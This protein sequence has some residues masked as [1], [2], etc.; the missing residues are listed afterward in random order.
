MVTSV[1]GATAVDG[2]SG[3]LGGEGD[4]LVFRAARS[5]ADTIVVGAGT[6]IAES[7]GPPVL[8]EELIAARVADGQDAL[9]RIVVVSNSLG[10][11]TRNPESLAI[12][13]FSTE[14][15]RPTV[16]T[17]ASTPQDRVSM[18]QEVA[19]VVVVGESEV[20]LPAMFA[21][22][23]SEGT[24]HALLE[25]GP[26]LN[27]HM[28]AAGLVDEVLLTFA[29]ALVAGPSN[30]FAHGPGGQAHSLRLERVLEGDSHLFLRYVGS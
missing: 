30:R 12:P 13:L 7:Y 8:P 10:S 15:F 20:D 14:G 1:D 17:A 19:D 26:T 25:G 28:I 24:N 29:P 3:A 27:G 23:R 4:K 9:P 21:R 11:I 6:A 18:L 5:V 22:L 16:V 2:A